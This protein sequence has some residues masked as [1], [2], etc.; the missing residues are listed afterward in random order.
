MKV[1]IT[2]IIICFAFISSQIFAQE[3]Q[4]TTEQWIEDL[5][6]VVDQLKEHH[7]HIYYRI[8]ES[9]FNTNVINATK[10]IKDANTDLK[11]YFAIKKIVAGI[12]DGHTRII[13]NGVFEIDDLRFPFRIDKF[14]DGVFIT[15]IQKKY[16]E[17]LGSRV[18]S[19]NGS[20]IDEVIAKVSE[21]INWDNMFGRLHP[22][23][24]H[25]TFAKVLFGLG[26]IENE[27]KANITIKTKDGI[28]EV[29]IFNAIANNSS[30]LRTARINMIPTTTNG[31]ETVTSRL[32]NNTPLYLK[33]SNE[34]AKFYWFEH[35]KDKRALYFQYNQV[36]S[37]P[38]HFETWAEFNNR[39]WEYID[40][41]ADSID[42]LII[43]I[44]FNDGGNGLTMY[45]FINQI[46]KR[47][48]FSQKNSLY[49]IMG[50]RTYSAPVILISELLLHTNAVFV[51]EPPASSLN[52]F[53]NQ[54]RVGRLPNSKALFGIATR[55]VSTA[56]F[57]NSTYFSPDIAAITNSYEYFNGIDPCLKMI[58]D[59]DF[60]SITAFAI[61]N[62][63]EK[64]I[65]YYNNLKKE[66]ATIKW[67][68]ELQP[69]FLEG[70]IN[71]NAYQLMNDSRIKEAFELFKLN[72]LVF[73]D[74]AN[75][76]DSFAEWHYYEKD[77]KIAKQFYEKS[78]ELNPMNSNAGEMIERIEK[79]NIK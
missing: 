71:N 55:T 10:E 56:A 27:N 7:P 51:G 25:C 12:Q 46:I 74:S 62:G 69:Q 33:E 66:Y 29:I 13:D 24:T 70:E 21:I 39:L 43:D 60:L 36:A 22:S 58:L 52:F 9:D 14:S 76:W 79:L 38:G 32:N 37:Q 16:S 4:F 19:I 75:A 8:S 65:D 73:P 42:K 57:S 28:K 15:V 45:P 2:T 54:N 50:N 78:L 49:V 53:S 47:E 26:I 41:N 61:K 5:N 23:L 72:T 20:P 63:A 40:N 6:Y 77:Y 59:D 44:R 1:I 11:C 31:Y 30:E 64:T 67:W 35:L 68:R 34:N 48:Q 18:I 17:Y 3:K